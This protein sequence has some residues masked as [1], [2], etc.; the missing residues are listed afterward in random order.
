MVSY[1]SVNILHYTN[2]STFHFDD[3]DL[4]WGFKF[5]L[6]D[7]L[8]WGVDLS[9]VHYCTKDSN[10]GRAWGCEGAWRLESRERLPSPFFDRR[11]SALFRCLEF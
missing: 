6:D 3:D 1:F 8:C 5:F 10:F 9:A 2:G 4:C 7:D 11:L